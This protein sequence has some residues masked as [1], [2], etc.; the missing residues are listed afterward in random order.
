MGGNTNK[1]IITNAA[2]T[3]AGTYSVL[4]SNVDNSV[5]SSNVTITV[6]Q[7]AAM[8]HQPALT[9]IWPTNSQQSLSVT[10]AGDGL[11]YQWY[12][13][14][15]AVSGQTAS[16]LVF[17]SLAASNSGT[18][19]L[20]I[21]NY[22]NKV[23][24]SNFL[25]IPVVAP[26]LTA[27][28][29][30]KG[31]T[32]GSNYTMSVTATGPY[33]HYYWSQI[34]TNSTTYTLSSATNKLTITNAAYT[35]AGTYSVIVSNLAATVTSSVANITVQATPVITTQPLASTNA[36]GATVS[37]SVV[38]TGDGL[39]FLWTKDSKTV[40]VGTINTATPGA[41]T[42]NTLTISTAAVSNRGRIPGHGQQ[43][44]HVRQ[45]RQCDGGGDRA[46]NADGGRDQR[47]GVAKCVG[48]PQSDR[49]GN[50]TDRLPMELQWNQRHHRRHQ[51]SLHD[52]QHDQHRRRL[53]SAH[54]HNFGGSTVTN[55]IVKYVADT[56][57]P[58]LT[59]TGA[60]ATF[61]T[62]NLSVTGKAKDN[63][64]VS[65]VS[66]SL[67]LGVNFSNAVTSNG[68][69]N[70]VISGV[71][72]NVGTNT[73]I[74]KA[75]NVNGNSTALL[76]NHPVYAPLYTVTVAT[77]GTGTVSSNWTGKVQWGKSYS[78]TAQPGRNFVLVGWTGNITTNAATFKFSP[79]NNMSLTATFT[80]NL[81]IGF[82]GS[83]NGLFTGSTGGTNLAQSGGYLAMTVTTNQT[84]TGKII[85]QGVSTPLSGSFNTDGTLSATNSVTNGPNLALSLSLDFTNKTLVGTISCASW[86]STN[87]QADLAAFSAHNTTTNAGTYT[88]VIP[89]ETGEGLGAGYASGTV[90]GHNQWHDNLR[91]RGRRRDGSGPGHGLV[92]RRLLAVL[93]GFVS[94]RHQDQSR[95]GNR[96]AA[97]YQ[98]AALWQRGL[99]SHKLRRLCGQLERY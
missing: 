30:S 67:D 11:V 9:N 97:V 51:R 70:F 41:S 83:Y 62:T 38:A 54:R 36:L 48:D 86:T 15:A 65:N 50:R 60:G 57:P 3:N 1:L 89:T 14:S 96:L 47:L 95:L 37:L 64:A 4:V 44:R 58:V 94:V 46:A 75:V 66:F 52:H 32:L 99:G 27:Q 92:R 80:T 93:R 22:A 76:T 7:A 19:S 12:K 73:L 28:P 8:S 77:S 31:M 5:I 21:S 13:G 91:W 74:V 85:V 24:S 40:T 88:L 56:N 35:N 79:T 49:H 61:S 39:A 63:V 59:L 55:V 81:F 98:R 23:T 33:L 90:V 17:N 34:G 68:W 53:L 72:T 82:D 84:Y 42:T 69:T 20:V 18:Y 71:I 16:N 2:Y 45:E 6:Q 87:L 43:S 26:V 29:A 10:T 25:V 78:L